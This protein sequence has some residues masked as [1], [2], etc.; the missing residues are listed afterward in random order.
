MQHAINCKKGGL[1]VRRH[2]ELRGFVGDLANMVWTQVQREVVVQEADP[3]A[4]KEGITADLAAR[5][6]WEPQ[7]V[8]LFD[9]K[10]TDPDAPS[11]VNRSTCAILDSYEKQKKRHYKDAVKHQHT[12][13]IHLVATTVGAMGCEF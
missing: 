9:F 5:G 11:Y 10:V 6:V 2:N 12:H 13:F 4:H 3:A 7:A 8:A 1:V